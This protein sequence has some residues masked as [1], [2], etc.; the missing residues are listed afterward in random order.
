MCHAYFYS[1]PF[2]QR[3]DLFPF[4]VLDLLGPGSLTLTITWPI[5]SL[6]ILVKSA[7]RNS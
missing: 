7:A 5:Y 2:S 3:L 1:P 4:Q 6:I